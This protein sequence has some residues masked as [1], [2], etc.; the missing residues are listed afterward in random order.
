MSYELYPYLYSTLWLIAW[1]LTFY[2]GKKAKIGR[3]IILVYLLSSITSIY[4]YVNSAY[5][6]SKLELEPYIYLFVATSICIFPFLNCSNILDKPLIINLKQSKF[7][8]IF[9]WI[10]GLFAFEWFLECCAI[11]LMHGVGDINFERNYE[12]VD[13]TGERISWLGRK[14]KF[15]AIHLADIIT[16]LLFFQLTR[17]VKDKK[18]IILLA[19]G[20]VAPMLDGF[21]GGHRFIVVLALFKYLIFYL[22]F[23]EN[24]G[25]QLRKYLKTI[26]IVCVGLAS[27]G[28]FLITLSRFTG[29]SGDLDILTWLSLYSGEGPLRFN[30]QAWNM[31]AF[32]E[33]DNTLCFF[34]DALGLD[35]AI[36][37]A[38]K[39]MVWGRLHH[40]QYAVYYTFVGDIFFDFGPIGTFLFLLLVSMISVKLLKR[41]SGNIADLLLLFLILKLVMFGFT[42]NPYIMYSAQVDLFIAICFSI[43]LK[44]I[45]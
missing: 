20:T 16:F 37:W 9:S 3:N 5:Y 32:T 43:Y 33:G 10:L 31:D 11:M 15:F 23:S 27:L 25:N 41:Y 21:M 38:E 2:L 14:F 13:F 22:L 35:T 29:L 42:Y 18:L 4:F 30:L 24:L 36:S 44:K 45:K 7:L 28:L 40:L 26:F 39:E 8:N 12:G 34:K 17:K 6:G 1:A 19:C